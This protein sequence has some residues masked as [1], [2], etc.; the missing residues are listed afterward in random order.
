MDMSVRDAILTRVATRRFRPGPV[1]RETLA[2]A[3]ALANQ[4][5]SSYNVQWWYFVVV[6]DP[7]LKRRLRALALDQAQ[8]E[9]AAAVIVFC[10]DPHALHRHMAAVAEAEVSAGRK[11]PAA[12]ARWRRNAALAFAQGPLGLLGLVKR[13]ILPV[14]RLT[15]PFPPIPTS[16]TALRQWAARETM[17]AVQTFMLAARG[18]GLD[19]CPM[20]AFDEGRLRRLLGI[21]RR[22]SVPV[23]VAVGYR[24][25]HLT[26]PG[27]RLPLAGKLFWN[28][29]SDIPG[30]SGPID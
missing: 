11:T 28:V 26:V 24:G 10:A 6:D 29:W 20:G 16:P 4:A 27:P 19:T 14:W 13:L 18:L 3:L 25:E 22:M 2:E 9:D 8:A 7:G 15:R 17:L 1:P 30:Q 23:I 12:A 21:P 5:P